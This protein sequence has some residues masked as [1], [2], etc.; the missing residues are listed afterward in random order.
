MQLLECCI[1][2]LPPWQH[3]ALSMAS[4]N[5]CDPEM[6]TS[7]KDVLGQRLPSSAL[8]TCRD[9]QVGSRCFCQYTITPDKTMR[10]I[11][12]DR[13]NINLYLEQLDAVSLAVG[14]NKL[15]QGTAELAI[16]LACEKLGLP[17]DEE[18]LQESRPTS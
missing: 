2:L 17:I 7:V 12:L 15:H 10:E 11:P 16:R 6:A 9:G 8:Q 4:R 3:L 13:G 14:S 18:S 1:L 5:I